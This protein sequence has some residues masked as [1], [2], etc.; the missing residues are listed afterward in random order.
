MQGWLWHTLGG[1]EHRVGS[2]IA[3]NYKSSKQQNPR[4]SPSKGMFRF[5]QKTNLG[6]L[7][8]QLLLELK[9]DCR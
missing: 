8:K 7:E 2:A 4:T 6:P 1:S 3:P 5:P 9:K